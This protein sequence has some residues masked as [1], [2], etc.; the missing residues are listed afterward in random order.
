MAQL[1]TMRRR[2]R[3][4][5]FLRLELMPRRPPMPPRLLAAACPSFF[6]ATPRRFFF[7]HF[8]FSCPC[9]FLHRHVASIPQVLHILLPTRRFAPARRAPFACCARLLLRARRHAACRAM[10]RACAVYCCCE[11]FLFTDTI[12][13]SRSHLLFLM[14]AMLCHLEGFSFSIEN[15][16]RI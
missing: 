2:H 13:A 5:W 15:I 14:L 12:D 8:S 4:P 1:C 6:F 11:R 7:R 3:M 10:P 16:T 9:C